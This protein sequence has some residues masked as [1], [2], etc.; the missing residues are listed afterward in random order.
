MSER[1]NNGN[2]DDG[3]GKERK[4]VMMTAGNCFDISSQSIIG[5]RKYD[6]GDFC[7]LEFLFLRFFHVFYEFC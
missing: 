7:T 5:R 2:D 4:N 3:R 1:E 6:V